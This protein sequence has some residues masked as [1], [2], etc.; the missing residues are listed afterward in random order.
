MQNFSID[1]ANVGH[2]CTKFQS[3]GRS[4]DFLWLFEIFGPIGRND[5][6]KFKGAPKMFGDRYQ[7]SVL[8]KVASCRRLPTCQISRRYDHVQEPLGRPFQNAIAPHRL[9]AKNH[10]NI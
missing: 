3:V 6:E 1:V 5:D 9:E 4:P 2:M 8:G 7:K 10:I